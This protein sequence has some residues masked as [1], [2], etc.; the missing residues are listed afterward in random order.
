MQRLI[1]AL[2]GFFFIVN[3]QNCSLFRTKF[4]VDNERALF[5]LGP[6][7]GPTK[8]PTILGVHVSGYIV[9]MCKV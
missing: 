6:T 3:V 9:P 1:D 2:Q 5:E 4:K 7:K 8:G